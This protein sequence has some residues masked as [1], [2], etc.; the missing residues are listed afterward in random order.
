MPITVSATDLPAAG[1]RFG[2]ILAQRVA[3]LVLAV[4][5]VAGV[6]VGAA[7]GVWW[8]G[9]LT[10]VV[11][12]VGLWAGLVAPRLGHAEERA[13]RFLG[14]VRP[15]DAREARLLNLVE[16]L[17]PGAGLPRP[18]CLVLEDR[19][20]NALVVGR[21]ARHG[22]LAVTTGLLERLTLMELE[23]VVAHCLV[24]LRDG[25]TVRPTLALALRNGRGL[26]HSSTDPH[27]AVDLA[28]VS[29]TRYPPGLASALRTIL[30]GRAAGVPALP[31]GS[32][33]VLAELWVAPAG[34]A[35]IE[36]RIEALDE[37]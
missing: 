20:A 23:G 1:H 7:L 24:D 35:A 5:A 22:W 19:S 25:S 36:A 31:S 8:A 28:A 32:A 10:L 29:L 11:V 14:P 13:L 4:A 15:A 2:R 9:V 16:G 21:D 33:A 27:L 3:A 17:A 6:V 30:E 26:A 37:M 18:H 34:E 12:A